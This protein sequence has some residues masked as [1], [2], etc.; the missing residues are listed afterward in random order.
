MADVL[1]VEDASRIAEILQAVSEGKRVRWRDVE[2]LEWVEGDIARLT[3]V[4]IE[5]DDGEWRTPTC[6]YIYSASDV[7]WMRDLDADDDVRDAYIYV[8]RGGQNRFGEWVVPVRIVIEWLRLGASR[9]ERVF[10]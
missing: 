6:P 9:G 7:W 10:F 8:A 3:M 2:L 5:G 1:T 4:M